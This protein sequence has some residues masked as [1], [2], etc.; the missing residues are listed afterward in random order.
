[1]LKYSKKVN[2]TF[3]VIEAIPESKH[4]KFWVVS[5][6]MKTD[7]G[8]QAPN[9]KSPGNTPKASLASSPSAFND[10]ISN[11]TNFVNE[12]SEEIA[13]LPGNVY[14]KDIALETAKK[15]FD[16]AYRKGWKNTLKDGEVKNSI[17][18][19]NF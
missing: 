12:H 19:R 9:A 2:G 14:G 1:M 6:Y 4:K 3:Y 7:S 5:A 13:P 17:M 11:N 15:L 10:S 16:D 8:T 18:R